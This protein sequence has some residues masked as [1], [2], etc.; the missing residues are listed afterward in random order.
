MCRQCQ[1]LID[2]R[3]EFNVLV[4]VLDVPQADRLVTRASNDAPVGQMVLH[5]YDRICM[6]PEQSLVVLVALIKQA[7]TSIQCTNTDPKSVRRDVYSTD[8]RLVHRLQV[9][10]AEVEW[11]DAEGLV[12][13]T[14]HTESLIDRDRENG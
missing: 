8:S 4:E 2:W 10:L 9:E 6:A 5:G 1:R 11:P 13:R 3:G 12:L 7:D 14:D